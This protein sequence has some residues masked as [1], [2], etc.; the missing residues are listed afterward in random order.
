MDRV[1]AVWNGRTVLQYFDASG[2]EVGRLVRLGQDF[3][4]EQLAGGADAISTEEVR[5]WVSRRRAE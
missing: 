2:P 3:A 1:R 5:D 4:R